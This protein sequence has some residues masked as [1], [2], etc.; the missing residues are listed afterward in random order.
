MP[1]VAP[2]EDLEQAEK[3]LQSLEMK[4]PDAYEDFAAFFARNRSV[5]YSN[6]CKM[7]IREQ[8]AKELK[9]I[10]TDAPSE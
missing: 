2:L 10:E 7:L 6:L 8:T 5:G 9:G 1:A 4:F 3:E